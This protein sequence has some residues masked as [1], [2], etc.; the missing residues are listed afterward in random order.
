ME[1]CYLLNLGL[2]SYQ[3]ALDLQ[4]QLVQLRRY[5]KI[6][7]MLVLLEHPSVLTFGKRAHS[8]EYKRRVAKIPYEELIER[9]QLFD[10]SRGGSVVC[11][12]PGQLVGY[13]IVDYTALTQRT[14]WKS[15]LLRF[16]VKGLNLIA[17]LEET[18]IKTAANY[19]VEAVRKPADRHSLRNIG[20][21]YLNGGVYKL[22]Y[23]G[24]DI[25][26]FPERRVT[27]H[28][29]ALNVNN[30]LSTFDV[31]HSCG[32]TDKEDIT[33]SRIL[34]RQLPMDDVRKVTAI[35]FAEVF[36]YGM[37]EVENIHRLVKGI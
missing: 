7:D 36:G 24:V 6:P 20:V 2:T 11:H 13:T 22:G 29:F 1:T 31:V 15:R 32:L 5:E 8:E 4:S 28:G 21:W 19:G 33:I 23:T 34:G 14:G 27:E 18:M 12:E 17:G 9:F 35:N 26:A 10:I 30:D 3:D 16:S 25:H 37:E